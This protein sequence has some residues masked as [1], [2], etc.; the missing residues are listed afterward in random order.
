MKNLAT[1]VSGQFQQSEVD[2]AR[3]K[4]RIFECKVLNPINK[5]RAM[6]IKPITMRNRIEMAQL[7]QK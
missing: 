3:P 5:K 7:R 2:E 1:V 6:L 4:E